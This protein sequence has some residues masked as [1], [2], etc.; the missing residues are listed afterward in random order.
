MAHAANTAD[1]SVS[2]NAVIINTPQAIFQ[3]SRMLLQFFLS[4][5]VWLNGKIGSGRCGERVKNESGLL[6]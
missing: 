2:F 4:I 6:P 3:Q 5:C 1:D